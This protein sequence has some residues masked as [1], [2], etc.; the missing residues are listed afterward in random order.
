MFWRRVILPVILSLILPLPVASQQRDQK[1]KKPAKSPT[2]ATEEAAMLRSRA[3]SALYGL[4][5]SASEVESVAERVRILA[6]VGDAL[7]G[8]DKEGAR[9][10]LIRA[11]QEI[12]KLSPASGSNREHTANQVRA[13]RR[14]VLSRI[15]KHDPAQANRIIHSQINETSAPPNV[16]QKW[17]SQVYGVSTPGGEALL[18]IAGNLLDSDAKQAAAL[19]RYSLSDGLSQRLRLFLI[20]LRSKDPATADMLVE[21]A[22]NIASAQH[23]GRLFDVLLLW[24]YAYQPPDFYLGGIVWDREKNEVRQGTSPALKRAILTF[25][26]NTIIENVQQLT[27]DAEADQGRKFVQTQTASLYSVIQQL[28]PTIQVDLPDGVAHLQQALVTVEQELRAA[29]QKVPEHPQIAEQPEGA[30]GS[31]LVDK[32]LEKAATASGEARDDLYLGVSFKLLQQ[33][34]YRRAAEVALKIDDPVRRAVIMEPINFG[35]AGERLEHGD[36]DG[37]LSITRQLNTPTLRIAALARIGRAFV[38][39]GEVPGGLETLNEAQSL[40]SKAEPTVE[41]CAATLSVAS[42]LSKREPMRAGEVLALAIQIMNKAKEDENR[43]ALMPPP[44]A[45]GTLNFTWKDADNGGLKWIKFSYPLNAGL[46]DVLS[47]LDFDQALSLAREIKS[48]G[49]SLA[50]QAA[51]YRAAIES[52]QA[53]TAGGRS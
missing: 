45:P 36:G 22:L 9:A 30:T 50:V 46:A 12:D 39:R 47:K 3:I 35:L 25:A 14:M 20:E 42:A 2:L 37:A 38:E 53:K 48:K 11:F 52:T 41:L 7:W 51:I 44:G 29:G 19:A 8:A 5:Q 27:T 1:T 28:L 16:E 21:T 4:A 40:T 43:W 49:L 24:D 15:A 34:Q 32:M 26:V 23:P 33:R 31:G 18:G 13:L 6:E 10:V 17:A